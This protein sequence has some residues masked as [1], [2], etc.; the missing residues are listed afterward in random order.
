[1]TPSSKSHIRTHM[2]RR[3]QSLSRAERRAASYALCQR[4]HQYA[5]FVNA[6]HLGIYVTHD[7]EIDTRYVIEQCWRRGVAV[8]VPILDPVRKGFLWFARYQAQAPVRKNKYG[9]Q[10]PTRSAARMAP[11]WLHCVVVP[12]V[13]FTPSGQRLGMGG[14]YYD[15]TF[16][17]RALGTK[18]ATLVGVAFDCQ[19]I[20]SLP[21]EH[22]DV[23]LTAV[24]TEMQR[25]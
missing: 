3:R 4:L 15:R 17:V 14:G 19:K 23:P 13:A 21:C 9:I 12:L 2:R 10:E 7:D 20:E 16:S 22:W 1:M 11:K 18:K 24:V 8:Y 5:L 6:K 25:Y